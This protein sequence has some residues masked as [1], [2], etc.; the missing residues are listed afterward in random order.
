MGHRKGR[1]PFPLRLPVDM[2]AA[3]NSVAKTRVSPQGYL[4]GAC[5][6]GYGMGH[7]GGTAVTGETRIFTSL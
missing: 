2:M 4:A 6:D 7:P 5:G 3:Q 1:I